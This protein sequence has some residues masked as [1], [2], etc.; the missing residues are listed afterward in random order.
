MSSSKIPHAPS[1]DRRFQ[2]THWS[3][4]I[5][6]GDREHADSQAALEQL[7]RDYWYPVFAFIR[8]RVADAHEAQD[9]TQ[10][11]FARLLEKNYLA[12]AR[13]ERGRFRTFLL[14]ATQRFVTKEWAKARAQKR[15]GGRV[16]LSL[17]FASGETRYAIEPADQTTPER[18]FDRRWALQL[19]QLVDQQLRDEH[20]RS[21][22]AD[23]FEQ[24][25]PFVAGEPAETYEQLAQRLS[26]SAG[27][28]RTAVY[29]LRQRFRELIRAEIA[30]TVATEADIADE[31]RRLF[32]ALA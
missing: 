14:T 7:C 22:K 29:R 4:V 16:P 13:R 11:F 28:A 12:D 26:I 1:G 31:V 15:G 17:D 18:E 23:E 3:L 19:L 24:L 10:A 2:T 6:A 27:A 30:K 25:K 21:G 5:A 9:L 8:R 32:D 20:T